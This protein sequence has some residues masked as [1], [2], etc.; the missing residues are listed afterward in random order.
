MVNW[1]F[2][3]HDKIRK[4]IDW[5]KESGYYKAILQNLFFATLNRE[6]KDRTFRTTT[7]GKPNSNNYLVTNIYRYQN[8]FLQQ[9]KNAI[10][11]L[12]E[13]TP[14][15]NGGLFECLD[16]DANEDEQQAYEKDRTIRKERLAIRV[17]GFSDRR[18]Q[19]VMCTQRPLF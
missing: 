14:F 5:N 9:D 16:R 4:I 15:L 1:D 2:F 11:R 7:N 13:Q 3:E 8:I 12:F 10:L 6:I 18:R 17:D 19:R